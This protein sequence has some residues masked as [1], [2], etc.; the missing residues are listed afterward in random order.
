MTLAAFLA[1]DDGSDRRYQL[2]HGM[3]VMK[4]PA[5]ESHRKLA[6]ALMIE[7]GSRLKRSCRVICNAGIAVEAAATPAM[8]PTSR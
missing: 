2:I 4:A 5:A 1:W 7:I 6:A 8:S 3:P